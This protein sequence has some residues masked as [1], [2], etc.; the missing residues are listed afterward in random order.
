[1][2][3]RMFTKQLRLCMFALIALFFSF[4]TEGVAQVAINTNGSLPSANTILDLNPAIGKALVPP[5]MNYTQIKAI[6][7]AL[8]GMTVYD[9]EFKTLRL[10][11]GTKWVSLT[12]QFDV[13]APTGTLTAQAPTGSLIINGV[14]T[15]ASGNVYITGSFVGT[16]T[17]GTV[18]VTG[19]GSCTEFFLAKYNNSGVAQWVQKS[20]SNQTSNC[21]TEGN[22]LAVDVSGNIYATGIFLTLP[23]PS[24]NVVFGSLPS[25]FSYPTPTNA[26]DIFVVKYNSSGVAQWAIREGGEGL[27]DDVAT[28]ITV[29]ASNN[30]YVAGYFSPNPP[31]VTVG[32][33]IGAGTFSTTTALNQGFVAK[34]NTNGV[35]QWTQNIDGNQYVYGWGVAVDG[36]SNVYLVGSFNGSAY[37]NGVSTPS[38]GQFDG[39]ITKFNSAGALQWFKK[40]G[41]TG[42]DYVKGIA[43]NPSDASNNLYITGSFSS[44]ANFVGAFSTTTLTSAGSDDIFVA[45]YNTGGNVQWVNRAGGSSGSDYGN[46]I[47]IDASNNVFVAGSFNGTATFGTLPTVTASAN[48]VDI[49]MAK[50]TTN[51]TEQ[52]VFKA[53]GPSYDTGRRI[54]VD[55]L[56]N[57]YTVGTFNPTG[58]FGNTV[59]MG[60]SLGFLMKYSE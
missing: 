36:S 14:A 11:N 57:V 49:F 47:T 37:Y 28:A 41:G 22:A 35:G 1:M 54:V 45:K 12:Q 4:Y 7:P 16:A 39:F 42:N 3:N 44:S 34:Y 31:A 24:A 18:S 26:S 5:K 43:I 40:P 59:L 32:V 15:D 58:Q 19:S 8:E 23:N 10:Y 25:L 6:S 9:T 55:A 46:S 51:G 20:T 50:Y 27:S 29:D 52:F 17:F 53:G 30:I 38:A 2:K 48:S 21:S 33:T 56:N 60:T 13:F